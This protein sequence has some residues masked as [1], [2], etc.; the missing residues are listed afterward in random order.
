MYLTATLISTA[1]RC[2][3]H[4][5]MIDCVIIGSN[6][7]TIADKHVHLVL[8]AH[9]KVAC[10][11][12]WYMGCLW[13]HPWTTISTKSCY[14]CYLHRQFT[15]WIWNYGPSKETKDHLGIRKLYA[16]EDQYFS[17]PPYSS[18]PQGHILS[19]K[20]D[21]SAIQPT[22]PLGTLDCDPTQENLSVIT[23]S[24]PGPCQCDPPQDLEDLTG[25]NHQSPAR[26]QPQKSVDNITGSNP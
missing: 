3:Q 26:D 9:N 19:D 21:P 14:A 15:S 24:R 22:F 20:T 1:Q 4:H 16:E 11:C 23:G 10:P 8:S 5:V 2:M 12:G 6:C 25:S 18:E 7:Y 17:F 13:Q